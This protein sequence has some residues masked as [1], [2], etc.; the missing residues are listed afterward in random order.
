MVSQPKPP[1]PYQTAAAQTKS[2]QDTASYNAALN[3]V[4]TYTPYGNEIYSS[5]GKDAS[6]APIWRSDISLAPE[7]QAQLDNQLKQ[8][9]QI[10]G[11]GFTLAD[12][13]GRALGNPITADSVRPL[14]Y[15]VAPGDVP[16]GG[17]GIQGKADFSGVPALPGADD[18]PGLVNNAIGASYRHQTAFLDPRFANESSDL[19]ARLA[20]QGINVASNPAAWARS[21]DEFGRERALSYSDAMNTAVGQGQTLQSNLA[22]QRLQANQNAAMQSL[23]AQQQSNQAQQQEY[24]QNLSSALQKFS[25]GTSNAQLGNT[26]TAQDLQQRTALA[27]LPLNELS[28]VRSGTQIN[29]PTFT[30]APQANAAGTDISG[31]INKNYDTQVSNYNNTMSG[32]FGLGGAALSAGL[33]LFKSSD[34][35]LKRN[36]VQIGEHPLGIP[37]YEFTYVWGGQRQRGVMAQDV[38]KVMP[39]AVMVDAASGYMAVNY[40]AIG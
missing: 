15:S 8:N 22:N 9:T 29:N 14:T 11:L 32:I 23:V 3:R 6:G 1:D 18:Y 21:R 26:T 25:M 37:E 33:P 17:Q 20:N 31:L 10:S 5:S 38:I 16:Q 24:Q 7:A 36:I 39:S 12:Q 35:R 13:A 19:D 40:A 30:A 27:T 28:A 4:S 34:R 2:N